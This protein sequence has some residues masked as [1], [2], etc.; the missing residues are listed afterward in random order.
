[1]HVLFLLV[2]LLQPTVPPTGGPID[3]LEAIRI[4]RDRAQFSG[5]VPCIVVF[6]EALGPKGLNDNMFGGNALSAPAMLAELK[7]HQTCGWYFAD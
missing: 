6:Q 5:D 3:C 7:Q 2:A 1:M 4:A